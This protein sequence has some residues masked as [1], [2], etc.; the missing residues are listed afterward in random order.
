[1][2]LQTHNPAIVRLNHPTIAEL[3]IKEASL[4]FSRERL[5]LNQV[6]LMTK[7]TS[8]TNVYI[9]YGKHSIPLISQQ[10]LSKILHNIHKRFI[11]SFTCGLSSNPSE[12]QKHL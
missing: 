5:Q 1:M 7:H 4:T 6:Y 9:S 8:S 12:M 2:A 11:S 10:T 3:P